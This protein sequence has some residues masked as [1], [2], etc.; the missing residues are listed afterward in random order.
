MYH[1]SFDIM[2]YLVYPAIVAIYCCQCSTK[3]GPFLQDAKEIL[4]D[5]EK[6]SNSLTICSSKFELLSKNLCDD[7]SRASKLK[8]R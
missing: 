4:R 3:I 7:L 5:I 1:M 8:H 2:V 6:Y